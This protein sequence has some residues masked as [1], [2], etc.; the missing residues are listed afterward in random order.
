MSNVYVYN[1]TVTDI[2]SEEDFGLIS[3]SPGV[4]EDYQQI[5][6]T[7]TTSENWYSITVK[8]GRAHV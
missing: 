6:A 3:S 7:A 4:S 5:S 1:S 8:I 2:Y